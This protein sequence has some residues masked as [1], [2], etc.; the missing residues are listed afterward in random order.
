MQGA[1]WCSLPGLPEGVGALTSDPHLTSQS[2]RIST[3]A[4]H[5]HDTRAFGVPIRD[6]ERPVYSSKV[7][8]ALHRALHPFRSFTIAARDV[9]PNPISP[10]RHYARGRYRDCS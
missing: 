8:P 6:F 7:A 9:P 5:R 3:T 4:F 1:P 2:I 10:T